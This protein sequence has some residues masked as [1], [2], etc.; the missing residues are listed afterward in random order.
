MQEPVYSRDYGLSA[1][2]WYNFNIKEQALQNLE[3]IGI[4]VGGVVIS[5]LVITFLG[6]MKSRFYIKRA[7]IAKEKELLKEEKVDNQRLLTEDIAAEKK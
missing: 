2:D 1:L 3:F 4:L 5:H 6:N 7:G